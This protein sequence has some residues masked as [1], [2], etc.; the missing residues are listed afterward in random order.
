VCGEPQAGRAGFG[1]QQNF[2]CARCRSAPSRHFRRAYAATVYDAAVGE[3]IRLL[4]FNEKRTLVLH[5]GEL[6][7]AFADEEMD[8]DGYDIVV[9]VPLYRVRLRE[10]GFNQSEL[11]AKELGHSNVYPIL[12]RVRPTHVQSTLTSPEER[13]SNVAGAFSV[14]EG[15]D[16]R[17][18]KVL[19]VDDVVTSGST[20]DECSKVLKEAGADTVDV[21]ATAIPVHGTRTS[22]ETS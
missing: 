11:L 7:R 6:M 19:V 15:V 10:R 13:K 9:P 2:P 21:F 3:A 22:S 16:V 14:A 4:K 12:R 8:L 20:V 5:L 18:Q 1:A 17:G